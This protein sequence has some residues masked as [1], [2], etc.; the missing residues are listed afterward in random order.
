MCR[1]SRNSPS[2]RVYDHG[3]PHPDQIIPHGDGV[4]VVV[5]LAI[6]ME[7]PS[8]RG[9]RGPMARRTFDVIDVTEILVHWYAGRS[10]NEMSGS[11]GWTARRSASTSPR[12][13]LRASHRAPTGPG[14][15]GV[16][17]VCMYCDL[18]R[19][20]LALRHYGHQCHCACSI[21]SSSGSAAGWS[22]S[23]GH[24]PLRTPSC[25]C[26][27]TRSPCCGGPP[28]G[29]PDQ[30]KSSGRVPEPGSPGSNHAGP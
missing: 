22:C 24:R 11:W 19:R 12:R 20:Q 7:Q 21:S 29:P 10:P 8:S 25:P 27:G 13:S 2:V 30:V 18:R 17:E 1:R 9:G 14:A 4:R 23:A 28:R 16:P 6:E 5:D 26:C 15:C 3:F